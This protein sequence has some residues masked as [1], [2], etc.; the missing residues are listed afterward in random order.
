VI[1]SYVQVDQESL[2]PQE[3]AGCVPWS[4]VLSDTGIDPGHHGR[5]YC[6]VH[7]GDNLTSFAYN[8]G[9]GRAHCFACDWSGDKI[10]FLRTVLR[11]DFKTA[12]ARLATIAG[13]SLGTYRQPSRE[14]LVHAH[15]HRTA[16]AA[17]RQAY[18]S[19]QRRQLVKSTDRYRELIAESEIAEAAYRQLCRM[20]HLYSDAEAQYWIERLAAIYDEL[21]PLEWDLDIITYSEYE[22]ARFNWWQKEPTHE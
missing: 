20:P 4:A 2:S 14:K 11:C 5:T 7:H 18:A 8:E 13:I 9:T 15:A 16:L 22:E 6:G 12:L 1:R 21:A 3:I 17:A 10:A 19:W